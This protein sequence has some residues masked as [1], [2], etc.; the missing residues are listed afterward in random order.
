MVDSFFRGGWSGLF[1]ITPDWH[2]I[3]DRVPGI[4]GLYC[5]VGF[6][7]HGFKL[8]PAIGQVMAELITQGQAT[9]FNITPLRFQRFAEGDLMTSRYRYRVLA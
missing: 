7:G 8:S 4:E 5:A 1:T 2:P 9:S 6:S 3:L